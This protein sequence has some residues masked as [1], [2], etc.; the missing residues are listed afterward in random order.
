MKTSRLL[1]A[2]ETRTKQV[3]LFALEKFS[4]HRMNMHHTA[5]FKDS[6]SYRACF[7]GVCG[8]VVGTVWDILGRVETTPAC[9]G[10]SI[11]LDSLQNSRVGRH[12]DNRPPMFTLASFSF[13]ESTRFCLVTATLEGKLQ[14]KLEEPILSISTSRSSTSDWFTSC[15]GSRCESRT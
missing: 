11:P 5:V 4:L 14:K 12:S 15:G 3:D 13:R 6:R 1:P 2:A 10:R 8:W 7:C 9:A